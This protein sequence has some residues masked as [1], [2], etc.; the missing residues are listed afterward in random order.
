MRRLAASDLLPERA[1]QPVKALVHWTPGRAARAGMRT[2]GP[3]R[4]VGHRGPGPVWAAARAAGLARRQRRR[5]LAGR[6]R[7]PRHQLRRDGGPGGDRRVEPGRAG[8][9]LRPAVRDAG[10]AP[11]A[12][13]LRSPHDPAGD[14][15]AAG[16]AGLPCC[17]GTPPLTAHAR[18]MLRTGRSSAWPSTWSPAPAAWPASCAGSSS[19]P[20]WPGRA[21]R[22]T[23]ATPTPSR[24]GSAPR[25]SCGDKHC[26]WT[27]GCHQPA[28]ACE[29][30]HVRHKA[31]GGPTSVKDCIL[32]C[33]LPPPGGGP[34]LGLDADLAPGRHHHRL[35]P[36]Q[37]QMLRSHSPPRLL[38]VIRPAANRWSDSTT[39]RAGPAGGRHPEHRG[40]Q[41]VRYAEHARPGQQL[42]VRFGPRQRQTLR[43]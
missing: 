25:S 41:I 15:A 13:R 33:F 24:P 6:R 17:G 5:R 10:W 4:R 26:Q 1:G 11:R 42:R 39:T 7:G 2:P 20:G 28:A 27:G 21:C 22:S 8:A 18:E 37:D 30:H 43:R 14:P 31:D 34:P 12:Q 19:A 32:L 36:G 35:E 9:D 40:R 3:G 16:R 38:S 29:V 23:S